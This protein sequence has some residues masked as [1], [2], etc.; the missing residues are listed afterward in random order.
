MVITAGAS[1]VHSKG[2]V[3][4]REA[5]CQVRLMVLSYEQILKNKNDELFA[6]C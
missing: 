5:L 1:Q 2:H 6:G 3:S 4:N